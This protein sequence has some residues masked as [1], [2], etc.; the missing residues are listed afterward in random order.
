[1]AQ[2]RAEGRAPFTW[3]RNEKQAWRPKFKE[4]TGRCQGQKNSL[5]TF[6]FLDYIKQDR[7]SMVNYMEKTGP[8]IDYSVGKI[9]RIREQVGIEACGG[10]GE[11]THSPVSGS[12]YVVRMRNDC[13][14]LSL[15]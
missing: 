8:V 9:C 14:H 13:T 6:P 2:R 10:R 4:P 5:S 11:V 12:R 7:I 1:M 15:H 3:S